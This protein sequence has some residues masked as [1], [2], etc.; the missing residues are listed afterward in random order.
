M[1]PFRLQ[2]VFKDYLWGGE[3]LITSWGKTP[4]S[5]PLAESWELAAHPDGDNVILDGEMKG[6]TLSQA[7]KKN[8]A[9]VAP[10]FKPENIFPLMVKLIDSARPLSIQVHPDDDYAQRVEG[11]KGKTELWYILDS[12]PDSFLYLGFRRQTTRR[13]FEQAIENNTLTNI[14]QKIK[15]HAGDSFFIPAGT[16]HSIG[17]GITLVEIQQNSN[18][19]YRVYDYGRVGADGKPRE[20]HTQKALDV[21]RTCPASL[22]VPGMS[23]NFIAVC[24]EFSVRKLRVS[25]TFTGQTNPEN[26]RFLLCLEG[27]NKFS[28]DGF[29]CDVERGENIFIPAN[30]GKNFNIVGE[31]TFLVIE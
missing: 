11:S 15:V 2:P 9:V 29:E 13:E 10:N 24:K 19:T 30:C 27:K 17:A 3:K 8:P 22:E 23:E 1:L 31:G 7:V 6:L 28:C 20:L 26:F 14:L 21:A 4:S 25:G 12:E 5:R 18:I 16:V